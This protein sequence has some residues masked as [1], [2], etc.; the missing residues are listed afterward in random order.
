MALPREV[1]QEVRWLATSYALGWCQQCEAGG[2]T[3][4][5][6]PQQR[7]Q[8]CRD[9]KRDWPPRSVTAV[10]CLLAVHHAAKKETVVVVGGGAGAQMRSRGRHRTAGAGV[11]GAG[12]TLEL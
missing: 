12:T 8:P 10:V 7:R 9:Q 1:L 4:T 6:L 11:H 3:S 5:V 2:A